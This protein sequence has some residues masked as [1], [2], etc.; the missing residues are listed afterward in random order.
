MSDLASKIVLAL[1]VAFVT[2]RLSIRQF[3]SQKWW[4]R[5][6]DAYATIIEALSHELSQ[7][8][9]IMDAEERGET[10]QRD[11]AAIE[12]SK[13]AQRRIGQAAAAGSFIISEEAANDLAILRRELLGIDA[14]SLY[15][16]VSGEYEVM[17]KCLKALRERARLDLG[18]PSQREWL[19]NMLPRKRA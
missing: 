9:T 13:E 18:L 10:H 2:V 8:F 12:R 1:L 5:K 17:N 3:A 16:H 19:A 11:A 14:H 7:A 15:E 6:A 4:E